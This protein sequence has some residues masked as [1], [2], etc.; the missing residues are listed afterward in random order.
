MRRFGSALLGL[1]VLAAAGAASAQV[2]S[3]I[4]ARQNNFKAIAK[5]FK[6]IN[7]ELKASRPSLAVLRAAAADLTA[8]SQRIP[9]GF[10]AGSGPESGVKTEALPAI[11]QN[12]AGFTEVA[13]RHIAAVRALE[14]AA[15]SGDIARIRSATDAVGP[16]CKACHD[17]FRLKK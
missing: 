1:T 2:A 15:Q 7:D 6:T 12:P 10:P 16:T 4:E 13:N 9:N 8:A 14:A 17:Q 3:V 11:W 5:A